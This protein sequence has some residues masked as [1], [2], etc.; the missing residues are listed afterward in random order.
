ML[1]V[2]PHT[3]RVLLLVP[4]TSSPV[5][6]C[7]TYRYRT[8]FQSYP[9]SLER[10]PQTQTGFLHP[11]KGSLSP[12]DWWQVSKSISLSW[13]RTNSMMSF[14]F[15]SSCGIMLGLKVTPSYIISLLHI[16]SCC[17]TSSLISLGTT[18]LINHLQRYSHFR[19]CFL[20]VWAKILEHYQR[21]GI[22]L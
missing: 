13:G 16:L 10:F 15:R 11:F 17:P 20:K 14:M 7:F 5:S 19:V 22:F 6:A 8:F 9:V 2:H 18:F 4:Y 1:I 21:P 3:Y 12:N